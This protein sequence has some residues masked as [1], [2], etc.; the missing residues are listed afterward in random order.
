MGKEKNH[1]SQHLMMLV[2]AVA[3]YSL[4]HKQLFVTG[5]V[6]LAAELVGHNGTIALRLKGWTLGRYISQ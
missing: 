5:L 4:Q 1:I 6:S 2:S 3:L